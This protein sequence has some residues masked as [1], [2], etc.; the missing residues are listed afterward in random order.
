ML[1]H[2]LAMYGDHILQTIRHLSEGL[3]LSLDGLANLQAVTSQKV[4]T[5]PNHSKELTPAKFQAW[6]MWQEDGLSI[7]KIA[8]SAFSYCLL[9]QKEKI[10]N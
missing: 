8:V 4:Y 2:L 6:K 7:Q 10:F 5:V 9:N 1:Q 3:D